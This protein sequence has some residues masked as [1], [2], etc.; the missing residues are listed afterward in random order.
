[1]LDVPDRRP[2]PDATTAL[3][4][5]ATLL[6]FPDGLV[7]RRNED[8]DVGLQRLC[9]AAVTRRGAALDALVDGLLADLVGSAGAA[10][11]IAIVAVRRVSCG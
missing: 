7:E 4:E 6:L 11:D 3:P 10:D 9:A 2:R 8:L 1:M 5:G